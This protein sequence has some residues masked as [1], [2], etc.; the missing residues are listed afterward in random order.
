MMMTLRMVEMIYRQRGGIGFVAHI[1]P[2]MIHD[3]HEDDNDEYDGG[4]KQQ[5]Q[6]W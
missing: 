4:K 2:L 1:E 5:P 3:T 6:T